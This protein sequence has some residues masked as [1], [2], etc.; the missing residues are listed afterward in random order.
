MKI[1]EH[2]IGWVKLNSIKLKSLCIYILIYVQTMTIQYK[3]SEIFFK[4]DA[5]DKKMFRV[6]QQQGRSR[7]A[8]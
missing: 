5:V 7:S 4:R 1:G 6:T 2:T 3:G 8:N